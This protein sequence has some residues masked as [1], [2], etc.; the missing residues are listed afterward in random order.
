[1]LCATDLVAQT[2]IGTGGTSLIT[3][4]DSSGDSS[5]LATTPTSP[6][7]Y[8]ELPNNPALIQCASL[9]VT[10]SD[11]AQGQVTLI[12]IIPGGQSFSIPVANGA[13]TVNWA[14][15]RVLAGT[16]VMLV[17][18]DDRGLGTG[19]SAFIMIVQNGNSGCLN[20]GNPVYSS[21]PAPYA[22]G[23]YATGSGGGTVTGPWQSGP[24]NGSS[25][26]SR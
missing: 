7:F 1:M 26:S 12:G 21:T 15:I 25:S 10:F 18:G 2:G 13:L 22:G 6:L 8:L 23:Q 4:V 20:A 3:D 19:G 11:S 14:P 5:C 16:G 17:A 9:Q 24:S